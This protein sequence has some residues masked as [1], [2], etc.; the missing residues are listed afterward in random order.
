MRLLSC[1]LRRLSK[2]TSGS[3]ITLISPPSTTPTAGLA[4]S[5]QTEALLARWFSP[6]HALIMARGGAPQRSG[7]SWRKGDSH[8]TCR[9]QPRRGP[10]ETLLFNTVSALSAVPCDG[11]SFSRLIWTQTCGSDIFSGV[12]YRVFRRPRYR[13]AYKM[14][15]EMEWKCCHGYSGEDCCDATTVA[16]GAKVD[17]GRPQ[18]TSTS[19]N[20]GGEQRGGGRG[21]GDGEK[22]RQL[23]EK[24]RDLTKDLRT[25]QT[26]IDTITTT[27]SGVTGN[28]VPADAG[29]PH[30]RDTIHHIQ[31]R[32]DQLSNRSQVHD[33]TLLHINHRMQ[34]NGGGND[35]DEAGEGGLPPGVRQHLHSLKEEIL[36]QLEGRV[37]LSCS[38]CQAGV[39][40]L[41]RQQKQDQDRIRSLEKLLSSVDQSLRQSVEASRRE[42]ER[43]SACCRNLVDLESR[44]DKE[45]SGGGG[46]GK[47]RVTEDRLNGRLREV[48]KR[49]NN[50][51]RKAEQ[52]CSNTGS[53]MK[54]V[55]Q[56]EVTQIRNTV[57]SRLDDHGFKIGKV[58]LDLTALG[59]TVTDHSGR[60]GQLENTTL[61]LDRRL[62]S[63]ANI[64]AEA[65]GPT[66]KDQDTEDTV[67]RLEWRVV[68]NQDDIR[69]FDT[70]LRDL[71]VSGDSLL[72]RVAH[73]A[74]DVEKIQAVTGADGERFNRVLTEVE[75]LGRD[76]DRCAVCSAVER[77]LRA[78]SNSTGAALARSLED[79]AD[80]RRRLD[81]DGSACSQVCSTLQEEVGRLREEV[82]ACGRRCDDGLDD[83]RRGFRN[84]T[85]RLGG[86]EASLAEHADALLDLAA[87]NDYIIANV[88]AIRQDLRD[89][90]EVS[91]VRLDG[92][93]V[94]VQVLR[95]DMLTE[96][97]ECR[98]SSDGLD[99]RL[100]RLEGIGGRL[101]AV[102]VG[103]RSVKTGL[104]RHV[105][106]LW[107]HVSGLN[108]TV[109][110]Q[111]GAIEDLERVQLVEVR[112]KV[113]SLNTT[114]LRLSE[115]FHRFST[116]DF[117]GPA[118]LPG[119]RGERGE[120]GSQ[121]QR[122][123]EGK[124]GL[125]GRVGRQGPVG[126]PGLRG[127][128]GPAGSDA[129]VPRL[130][131]SAA[132]T[133][134]M[135]SS[136]TIVFNKVLVNEN[137]VYNPN[138]GYFTAP[139]RG[140]YYFSATLTGHKNVKLEAVLS[141]SNQGVARGDSAG[142]QP[143]GLEKPMA[144]A[145]HLPGALAVFSLI[146]PLEAGET[147]CIDLV[148]GKLAHASEPLTVFS[149][150]LLYQTP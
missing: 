134:E 22:V 99:R 73:L 76:A 27:L 142:Y 126:P 74:E 106:G 122:G 133:R 115:E 12:H 64:C 89:H 86:A 88:S 78:F 9:M 84:V 68:S 44:L 105:S 82:E 114:L 90:L 20:A 33:Q 92:L 24:I 18:G 93:R 131:F 8:D 45:L 148:T 117:T 70:R 21:D 97:G 23:E 14:V 108:V 123:P 53:N 30:M 83:L 129:A 58:E 116:Q 146:L 41:R 69:T 79:L 32:L 71:S 17:A 145:L 35:V 67:K 102:S 144:E 121:G 49:L 25:M 63:V 100:A 75:T 128:E 110:T 31:N 80:L 46:G 150:A 38:S 113:G 65:C 4:C 51:A 60:L 59:D 139:V 62:A 48:E 138:T 141:R 147:V 66:G 26:T 2:V 36:T 50:T 5:S 143:E 136:G 61:S 107:R 94:Q 104:N 135:G 72:D 11:F 6:N 103:L 109:T 1:A 13:V 55:V 111:G 7:G 127:E 10:G 28:S 132:L 52:R 15:T 47:G 95:D 120:P 37:S 3:S 119:P 137:N 125:V 57:L 19:S 85:G 29:Q 87:A 81:S 140:R 112:S 56:R 43:S 91:R 149:G 16:T 124:E 40:D 42:T 39:E 96:V 101:D 77:D 34:E 118:G 98:R 54:D 130:S